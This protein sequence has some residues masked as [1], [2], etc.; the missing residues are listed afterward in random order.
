MDDLKAELEKQGRETGADMA[1]TQVGEAPA[2]KKRRGP[3]RAASASSLPAVPA[4]TAD[5]LPADMNVKQLQQALKQLG[6]VRPTPQPHARLCLLVLTRRRCVV[7][8]L[9]PKRRRRG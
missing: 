8:R 3:K 9:R 1:G 7:R 5:M 4:P 2:A 6:V